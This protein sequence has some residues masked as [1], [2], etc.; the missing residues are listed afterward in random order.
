MKLLT[1]YLHPGDIVFREKVYEPSDS[2][3]GIDAVARYLNKQVAVA[4][5]FIYLF[6]VN[7]IKTVLAYFGIIKAGFVCVVVDPQVGPLEFAEMVHSTPP[8]A[9]IRINKDT[10]SWDFSKEVVREH[11]V[12]VGKVFEVL[13]DVCT[14][15]YTAA[16]DGFAKAAML[17][18]ENIAA[19]AQAIAQ[20]N[21]ITSQTMTLSALPLSH[22]FG[23]QTGV[24]TPMLCAGN[25]LIIDEE[26]L[27]KPGEIGALLHNT[28]VTNLYS[29]PVVYYL[30][31]KLPDS[32]K[33]FRQMYSLIS[34]GYALP[35]KIGELFFKKT[36]VK[37]QQGYGLTEA[38]PVCTWIFPGDPVEKQSI[39]KALQCCRVKIVGKDN[40]EKKQGE[41]GE[42]VVKGTNVMKGYFNNPVATAQ[43]LLDG[44]LKTGDLGWQDGQG[45]VFFEKVEKC[46]I[47]FAG[48]KVYP[49][50]TERMIAQ[51]DNVERVSVFGVPDILV[52]E[53]V[54]ATIMLKNNSVEKQHEIIDWCSCKLTSYKIP[55][56]ILFNEATLC[57]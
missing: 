12:A 43:V 38:A 57:K 31:S 55:K 13:G 53:N 41:I 10:I 52:G 17:T 50:E 56:K 22:G 9:V 29:I 15:M 44:W 45:T 26:H 21:K 54:H 19:D 2:M 6:A 14:L 27:V 42:I 4:S 8:A 51:H 33:V 32:D 46:M 37:I 7:H 48:K 5:P 28:P 1:D 39:G 49:K 11:H 3:A 23:L 20:V 24:V 18:H 40:T 16:T 25:T 34:G 36:G 35:E 47:N 30:L